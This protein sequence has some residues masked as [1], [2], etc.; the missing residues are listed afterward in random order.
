[1]N[2]AKLKGYGL[3][4]LA[5]ATYGTNPVFAVPLYE[6]GMN[7]N[8]VLLFRYLLGLPILA[9]M[10]A[11][12][13]RSLR[14]DRREVMPL[15]VLGVMM[16]VSSLTLFASYEYMNVG[17]ASTMLFVYPVLVAVLMSWLYKERVK[18]TTI[19]CLVLMCGGLLL[20]MR[21]GGDVSVMGSV[22]VL[23]SALTY[24]VYLVMLNVS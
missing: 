11:C 10:L 16:A 20:M 13:G 22:L 14:I 23:V 17:V 8:S 3:A 15:S 7:P 5:A 4:A 6:E 19:A 18:V 21:G 9:A 24:A 1:M 2:I 12:R